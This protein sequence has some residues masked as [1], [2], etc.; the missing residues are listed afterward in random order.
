MNFYKFHLGDYY[1]K[2][3]HLSMLEDG[4]YRRLMDTIY[5]R[6]GPLPA[7]REQVHRLVKAFTKAEKTAVDSILAE[8][9]VLTD[10]GY[11]NARC[12]EELAETKERSERARQSGLASG[13]SRKRSTTVERPSNERSTSHK[14]LA[15]NS[16]SSSRA[17]DT[18]PVTSH[19]RVIAL[20]LLDRGK[21]NLSAWERRFLEDLCAKASI[22]SKM[23]ATLDGIAVMVGVNVDSVMATWRHR[24]DT[25]RKLGQWDVKWGPMPGQ[26]GCLAPQQLLE[27][28]DGDG[29][30]DWR[31]TS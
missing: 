30:T 28:G 11:T 12:D 29:W 31:P 16:S 5:L 3:S 7:D 15:S 23:Q 8:F 9:F 27:A 10:A 24:L 14:P 20:E 22:T 25:S 4:A 18:E 21:A 2:T 17:R 19:H 26:P 6:E 13:R 1:K